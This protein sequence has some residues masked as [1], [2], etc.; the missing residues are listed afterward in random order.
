MDELI[1]EGPEEA[2]RLRLN[3]LRSH[4][5]ECARLRDEIVNLLSTARR[6]VVG[7]KAAVRERHLDQRRGILEQ[8]R[9]F[10]DEFEDVAL[11]EIANGEDVDAGSIE[12][13]VELVQTEAQRKLF[14]YSTLHWSVPVSGGYGRRSRFLVRDR[15]NK[16]LIGVFALSDPV[17]NLRARDRAIG[18][19]DKDKQLGLYRVLDASVIG[20]LR[21]YSDLLGGKLVALTVI[22]KQ[23][24]DLVESKYKGKE[25][26]IKRRVLEDTRPVLVTTTSALGRSSIYNRI[27]SANRDFY[28]PLG[29]TE[30]YG[31]FEIPGPLFERMVLVLEESGYRK[32]RAHGYGMGP[33]WKMRAIRAAL[34]Y[35]RIEPDLALRHGIRRQVFAAPTARN[36]QGVLREGDTPQ[37]FS[38]DISE[39]AHFY[40]ERWGKPRAIRRPEYQQFHRNDLRLRQSVYEQTML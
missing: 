29:W 32:A 28:V 27:R 18:W 9:S 33:S 19:N 34:E 12:P 26:K 30:G 10:L 36:W 5:Q 24:L 39:L 23:T 37:W 21:P 17:Y 7:D 11:T 3:L 15:H 40:R 35:L 20:A 31:H 16:K 25:T 14:L 2:G 1:K 13:I 38:D 6:D 22:A 8:M 4:E